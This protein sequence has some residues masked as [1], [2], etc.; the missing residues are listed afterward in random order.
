VV[1]F[2][3][4]WQTWLR[5]G[6]FETIGIGRVIQ[7]ID[8]FPYA[9]RQIRHERFEACEDMWLDDQERVLYLACAGSLGRMQ[10]NPA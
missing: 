3:V 2:G 7:S 5:E 1:L 4:L 8:E 9:C 6:L 10:W